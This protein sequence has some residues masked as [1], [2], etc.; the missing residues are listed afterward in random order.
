MG[1]NDRKGH[2]MTGEA[3]GRGRDMGRPT[4]CT[5]CWRSTVTTSM[6]AGPSTSVPSGSGGRHGATRCWPSWPRW[7]GSSPSSSACWRWCSRGKPS[8]RRTGRG[9][10]RQDAIAAK[11]EQERLGASAA[12][13]AAGERSSDLD[14]KLLAP[15]YAFDTAGDDKSGLTRDLMTSRHYLRHDPV[16][17]ST[18]AAL[19]HDGALLVRGTERGLVEIVDVVSQERRPLATVGGPVVVVDASRIDSA[20]PW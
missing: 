5:S 19:S 16:T 9:R 6:P 15:L 10:A 2:L 13:S 11:D 20:W 7:S 18:D 12:W 1:E 3:L 17:A 4:T 8:A 14:T